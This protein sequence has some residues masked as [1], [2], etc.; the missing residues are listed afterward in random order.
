MTWSQSFINLPLDKT[1]KIT[2]NLY[3]ISFLDWRKWSVAL[4]VVGCLTTGLCFRSWTLLED[5]DPGQ[6]ARLGLPAPNSHTAL[7]LVSPPSKSYSQGLRK[8]VNK[9][10]IN[11][12]HPLC[13]QCKAGLHY[14]PCVYMSILFMSELGWHLIGTWCL[15]S[16]LLRMMEKLSFACMCHSFNPLCFPVLADGLWI[17]RGLSINGC[18]VNYLAFPLMV[19]QRK[20]RISVDRGEKEC[21]TVCCFWLIILRLFLHLVPSPERR[22]FLRN[23]TG[24]QG[25]SLDLTL[26][27]MDIMN[28]L[29]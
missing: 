1:L 27:S 12:T 13:N 3:F 23:V 7:L 5:S 22:H 20:C 10:L 26:L 19:I 17:N 16:R 4:L 6:P 15:K 8:P 14:P 29:S 21:I 24:I 2:G 18:W 9:Q 11:I 28:Q 25:L